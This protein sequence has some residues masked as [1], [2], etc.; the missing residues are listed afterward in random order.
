MAKLNNLSVPDEFK[1]K[2]LS[3]YRAPVL[4]MDQDGYDVPTNDSWIV[5]AANRRIRPEGRRRSAPGMGGQRVEK[6]ARR[7]P[8]PPCCPMPGS[9]PCVAAGEADEFIF[10]RAGPP[11][12]GHDH[13]EKLEVVMSAWG[14]HLLIDPGNYD[15][16]KSRWRWYLSA[17]PR[18]TRLSST[19]NGRILRSIPHPSSFWTIRG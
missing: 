6:A 15:Y 4:V 1:D 10:F 13:Q 7:R 14:A 11:G 12:I 18:T 16:D 8:I 9:T 5:N 2:I 19:A 3:M 17:P